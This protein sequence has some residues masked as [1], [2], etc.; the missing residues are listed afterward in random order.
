M[1]RQLSRLFAQI[2]RPEA[3]FVNPPKLAL[4]WVQPLLVVEVAYTEVT[5]AGT[6][7]QPSIK[8]LRTDVVAGDVAW[9][10]EIADRF[11]ASGT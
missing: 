6:L 7:R 10:D 2:A 9:D 3:P 11:A 5:E 1:I 8:G 4:H